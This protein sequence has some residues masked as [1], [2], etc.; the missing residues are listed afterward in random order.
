EGPARWEVDVTRRAAPVGTRRSVREAMTWDHRRLDA[1]LGAAFAARS[2]GCLA[3]ARRVF[4]AFAHGLRRHSDVE[5]QLLLPEFEER[6]GMTGPH[7]P[8]VVM[9]A[10]HRAVAAIL[11][12]MEEEIGDPQAPVELSLAEL[13]GILHDHDLKEEIVVYPALD[14]LLDAEASDEMVGRAQAWTRGC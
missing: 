5:E 14:R 12:V 10:E 13:R 2:A 7:G 9:R 6:S 1:L 11:R 3:E 4:A 8:S